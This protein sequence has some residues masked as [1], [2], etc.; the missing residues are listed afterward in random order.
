MSA[1]IYWFAVSVNQL[2]ATE[3]PVEIKPLDLNALAARV[4]ELHH[5][6]D[7]V[8]SVVQEIDSLAV[9]MHLLT[10][11]NRYVTT[12]DLEDARYFSLHFH[13][14][15]MALELDPWLLAAIAYQESRFNPN[16]YNPSDPSWGLMQVMPKFWGYAFVSECG[17]PATPQTLLDPE[18]AICYGAHVYAHY[19]SRHPDN[20]IAGITAYNNGSGRP[21][22]YADQ[23]LQH[24]N[25]L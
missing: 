6:Y 17:S 22:G 19:R 7:V 21:N 3:S 20:H 8:D 1:L 14:Y 9:A 18:V 12:L 11:N 5:R 2:G 13:R 4:D 16:A 24:R 15:G 25:S 10:K 23:V